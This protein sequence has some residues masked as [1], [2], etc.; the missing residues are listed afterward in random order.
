MREFYRNKLYLNKVVLTAKRQMKW[1]NVPV[2]PLQWSVTHLPVLA[3]CPDHPSED[4][5]I[6]YTFDRITEGKFSSAHIHLQE[7]IRSQLFKTRDN[8]SKNPTTPTCNGPPQSGPDSQYIMARPL[9]LTEAADIQGINLPQLSLLF[10]NLKPPLRP[11]PSS[12]SDPTSTGYFIQPLYRSPDKIKDAQLNL[13]ANK[14]I[15]ILYSLSIFQILHRMYTKKL[16]FIWQ[17]YKGN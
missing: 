13:I 4:T 1:D 8:H 9:K 17:P 14:Q 3:G 6:P 10:G 2:V 11:T 12:M 7:Q 5:P 16:S 15:I